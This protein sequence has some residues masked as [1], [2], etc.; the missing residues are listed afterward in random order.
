MRDDH[1]QDKRNIRTKNPPQ[2]RNRV[3]TTWRPLLVYKGKNCEL[4]SYKY[5]KDILK[6]R[7]NTPDIILGQIDLITKVVCCMAPRTE[8][9]EHRLFLYW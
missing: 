8:T 1:K 3:L 7:Y 5:L 9:R 2:L 4:Y 6:C